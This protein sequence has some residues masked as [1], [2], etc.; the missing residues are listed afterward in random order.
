MKQ[1][2][3]NLL[4]KH[5]LHEMPFWRNHGI[6]LVRRVKKVGRNGLVP[7]LGVR[8]GAVDETADLLE[9][10]VA[11]AFFWGDGG[12]DIRTKE[13]M[14]RD[15]KRVRNRR[16]IRHAEILLAVLDTRHAR[17]RRL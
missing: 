8:N 14:G 7:L 13:G 17:F 2:G 11:L 6:F 3:C 4:I 9:K 16:N 1:N 10:A 15:S 5:D 12:C